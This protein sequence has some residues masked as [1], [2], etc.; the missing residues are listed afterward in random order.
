[1]NK[2]KNTKEIQSK[3]KGVSREMLVFWEGNEAGEQDGCK[4]AE[5]QQ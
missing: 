4:V 2:G 5:K 1:M 3:A